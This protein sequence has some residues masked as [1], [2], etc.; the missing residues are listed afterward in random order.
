MATYLVDGTITNDSGSIKISHDSTGVH[1]VLGVDSQ[2]NQKRIQDRSE[3]LN[4]IASHEANQKSFEAFLHI[5]THDIMHL[6]PQKADGKLTPRELMEAAKQIGYK[7]DVYAENNLA[8]KI[9]DKFAKALKEYA[10]KKHIPSPSFQDVDFATD[11]AMNSI[12]S[13][14]PKAPRNHTHKSAR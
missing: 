6:D 8:V 5:I 14:F 13:I 12:D 2:L 7:G 10:D 4:H 1:A 11:F 9:D 3:Q